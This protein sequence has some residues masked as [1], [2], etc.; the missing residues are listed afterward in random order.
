MEFPGIEP[1]VDLFFILFGI[2]FL[3]AGWLPRQLGRLPLSPAMVYVGLGILLFT[4]FDLPNPDPLVWDIAAERLSELI[5]IIALMITG[6]K[7]DRRVGLRRWGTTW[8]LLVITMPLTIAGVALLGWWA[9]GLA[10]ASALLLGAVMAPTDPVLAEDVQVGEPHK[11]REDEVRFGLTSESGLNDGLAFPFTN[12]AIAVAVVGLAPEGWLG[13]WL[14]VD[15]LYRVGMGVVVGLAAGYGL[16]YL[17]FHLPRDRAF[18]HKRT[19]FVA[20][21][22][23]LLVYGVTEV[24]GGYGFIAVFVTPVLMRHLEW[25][26]KYHE[27]LHDFVEETEQLLRVMVLFLFGGAIAGG[28][29]AP[30]T[31]NAVLAGLAFLFLVRPLFGMLAFP[32]SGVPYQE[33]LA[34]S[35]F[36]IRGIG[37]FY[38]LAYALNRESFEGAEM[39]WA[40]VGFVVLVSIVVH[41][42]AGSPVMGWFERHWR[43][44]EGETEGET[45][46]ALPTD[47][48]AG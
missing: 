28:L 12:L 25:A 37:S 23:T 7:L 18:A 9:V 42:L 3:A 16:T 20:L 41:G 2:L 17:L 44:L 22:I 15:V 10:P 26:E 32:F 30:L 29:L 24:L 36:G 38:Y 5:V 45:T 47:T 48:R 13:D 46:D 39:L 40:L 6:L 35:F 11:G 33:R 19:G 34:L 27:E 4:L 43:E 1:R 14:L 8:R 31:L 21:A